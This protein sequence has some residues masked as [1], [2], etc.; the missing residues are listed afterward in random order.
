MGRTTSESLDELISKSRRLHANDTASSSLH[1]HRTV[2]ILSFYYI[3]ILII[4][5]LIIFFSIYIDC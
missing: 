1:L 3:S 5:N 4:F 2:C